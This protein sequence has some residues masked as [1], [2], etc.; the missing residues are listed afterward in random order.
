MASAWGSSWGVAWG[1]SWGSVGAV[2]VVPVVEETAV[3][4]APG[5]P[6]LQ[7]D[8]TPDEIRADRER[9]GIIPKAEEAVRTAA[10]I[11]E[12]LRFQEDAAA[13]LALEQAREAYFA[14]WQDAY[15]AALIQ[16]FTEMQAK[17]QLLA[18]WYAEVNERR[19]QSRRRKALLLFLVR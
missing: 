8:R 11:E 16:G 15:D 10:I 14:A 9:L 13:R 17:A 12:R 2:V 4:G 5:Y 18:Q 7:H 3:F 1:N 19:N 6:R